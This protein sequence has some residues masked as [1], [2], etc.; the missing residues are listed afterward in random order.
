MSE[1]TC[2]EQVEEDTK[3][4]P[5]EVPE[6]KQAKNIPSQEQKG[7]F[8]KKPTKVTVTTMHAP[9]CSSHELLTWGGRRKT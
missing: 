7:D 6:K 9:E 4:R 8:T 2:T 1:Y 3:G 5:Q